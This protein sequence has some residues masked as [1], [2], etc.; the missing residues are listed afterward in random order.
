[1]LEL[2]SLVGCSLKPLVLADCR[3]RVELGLFHYAWL[4][5]HEGLGGATPAEIYFASTPAHLA[6]VHRPRGL[7]GQGPRASP[8]EIRFLDPDRRLPFLVSKAA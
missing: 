4:R 5:P 8:F 2:I 7:P 1:V 6:A 3:R